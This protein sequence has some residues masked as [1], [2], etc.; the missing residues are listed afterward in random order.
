LRTKDFC[1]W[2]MGSARILRAYRHVPRGGIVSLN[3]AGE[4]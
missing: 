2:L 4:N 3:A 1:P